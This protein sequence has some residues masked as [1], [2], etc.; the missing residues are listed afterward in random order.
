MNSVTEERTL[1]AHD[2]LLLDVI[3]KQAGTLQKAVTEGT[4]NAIEAG[5]SATHIKLWEEPQMGVEN[6]PN[7]A[8][9][10]I[11]DDG[12]GIKT[13]EE[14][15]AHFETFGTP[16]EESEG[17]TWAKFRMG[18]GQMF[19]FGVNRWRTSQFQMDVDVNVK[20][21]T[22]SLTKKLEEVDGCDIHIELYENPVGGWECR[23]I[24][25]FQEKVREQIRFVKM[26]VFFNDQQVS[27]DPDTLT[28]DY[29]DDDGYYLFN[30]NST[31][32]IYN[33]G[34]FVKSISISHAGV[35]GIVVSKNQLDVNF[36]RNDIQSTC[37]VWKRIQQIVQNNKIKKAQKA[38]VALGVGQRWS[39][40][41]DLRDGVEKFNVL[42][43]KRIFRTAQGKWFTWNMFA[44]DS[45]PWTFSEEGDMKADKAMESG[46]ALCF[47]KRM[48]REMNY[49]GPLDKFFDWIM[50]EQL[51]ENPSKE[52]Y[53]QNIY[54][55]EKSGIQ[56]T[57]KYKRSNYL[58]YDKYDNTS[59]MGLRSLSEMFQEKYST[60]PHAKLS[61]VEK[62]IVKILSYLDCWDGRRIS[63][64]VS[65]VALAWTD[66]MSYITFDRNWL[67]KLNLTSKADILH[68]FSVGAHEMAHEENTA[69]THIHGPEYYERF[70]EIT[71]KKRGYRNPLY[72]AFDFYDKMCSARIEEKK[73]QEDEKE[74]ATKEKLG[75]K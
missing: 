12:C 65:T 11:K 47:S 75:L 31:L 48:V 32:K 71:H 23:S 56:D 74:R 36:A 53:D 46:T 18:R 20:G 40:L 25:A 42:S 66:G 21:L 29:E 1:Q 30:D 57:L 37:E 39:L 49:D 4:M 3:R 6:A 62:R 68:L 24:D 70:Y 69:G 67:K 73:A 14:I 38:H 41:R 26:P 5:G 55:W 28:W 72:H 16:H 2:K 51:R 13:Q 9:L 60:V 8:F 59:Q 50:A 35:G 45:R 61:K 19:A 34:V 7:K 15:E 27:V 64:G 63:I 33:L 44:K 43:G 52:R 58:I 17:K 54:Q 10:T 22:Y